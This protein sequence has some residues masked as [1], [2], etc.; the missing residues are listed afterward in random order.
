M[1]LIIECWIDISATGVYLD[2]GTL[3]IPEILL[4]N[5]S[6][7]SSGLSAHVESVDAEFTAEQIKKSFK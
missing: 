1:F 3:S 6:G 2:A 4:L 5:A 7:S